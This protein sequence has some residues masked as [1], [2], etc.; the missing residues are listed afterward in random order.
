MA[1]FITRKWSD[2]DARPFDVVFVDDD[3]HV[4]YQPGTTFSTEAL[5]DAHNKSL[6]DT[7]NLGSVRRLWTRETAI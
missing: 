7:A 1:R 3:N 6:I 5:A 4:Y 2:K